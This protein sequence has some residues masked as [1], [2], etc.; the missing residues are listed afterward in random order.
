MHILICIDDT[1]DLDSPGTGRLAADLCAILEQRR[2]ARCRYITR[3]QL[4]VHPDIPYTSHNAA[5]CFEADAAASVADIVPVCAQFLSTVPPPASDPGLCIVEPARLASAAPL[6]EFGYRA[7]RE[8]LNKDTAYA[9]AREHAIHLS[10]H[11][12]TGGGVIGALAGAGLR[13]AGNDGRLRGGLDF[14]G[15]DELSVDA[16][17]RHADVDAV[18]GAAGE[19]PPADALIRLEGKV[20]TVRRDG[21]AVLL[22]AREAGGWRC[23]TK[24]ELKTY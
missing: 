17:L 15:A 2:L 24:S 23:L 11:G 7:K 9:F 13:L 10:E 16:L 4:F 6:I 5:M 22:V 1:D 19:A 20:K 18:Q 8:V 12:G 3:H 14:G 21:R